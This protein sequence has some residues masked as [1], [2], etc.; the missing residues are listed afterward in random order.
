MLNTWHTL[1]VKVGTNF[2]DKRLSLGRYSSLSDSDHG[3][4]FEFR[5]QG[6]S[7]EIGSITS[8]AKSNDIIRNRI[9]NLQDCSIRHKVRASSYLQAI[10]RVS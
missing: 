7:S 2:A 4:C 5:P 1:S 6:T 3:D 8:N 10:L 9:C